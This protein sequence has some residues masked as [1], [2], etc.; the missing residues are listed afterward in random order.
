[1][2]HPDCIFCDIARGLSPAHTVEETRTHIVIA[3][4]SPIRPGHLLVLPRAHHACFDDLPPTLAGG[5]IRV[6]Q[7]M[8]R[9]LKAEYGVE[10]VGFV[11]TGT[12]VAH[13]HAHLVPLV[14]AGDITSRRYIPLEDVPFAPPPRIPHEEIAAT[15]ARLR[16][17]LME[18]AT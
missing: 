5:M 9:L 12:D 6:G 15:A 10:R 8:A 2:Y 14:E 17:R 7:R 3:E 1:M 18:D 13:V 4:Q 11:I 16:D